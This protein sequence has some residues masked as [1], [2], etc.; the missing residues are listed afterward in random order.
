VEK[1][2]CYSGFRGSTNQRI[3]KLDNVV[4]VWTRSCF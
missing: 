3:I 1:L 4:K 2:K